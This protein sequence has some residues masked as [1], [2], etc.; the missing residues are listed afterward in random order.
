MT[1]STLIDASA[2]PAG[3]DAALEFLMGARSPKG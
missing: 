2:V 1:E 3:P